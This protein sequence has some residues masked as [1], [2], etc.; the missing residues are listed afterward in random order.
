MRFKKILEMNK[1]G[2]KRFNTGGSVT[3]SSKLGRT[4]PTKLY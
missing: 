3:V 2:K 4:K 1:K